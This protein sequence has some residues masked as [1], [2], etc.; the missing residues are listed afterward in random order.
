M[1]AYHGAMTAYHAADRSLANAASR[2][3]L[4]ARV[5]MLSDVSHHLAH[6]H[7]SSHERHE[8]SA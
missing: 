2:E 3:A 7:L 4:K 5:H 1:A 8:H 6:A